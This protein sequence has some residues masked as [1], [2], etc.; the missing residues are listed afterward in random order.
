MI[1]IKLGDK[2]IN[3]TNDTIRIAS[4]DVGSVNFAQYIGDTDILKT[5]ELAKRYA[6]LPKT[7]QR[8]VKGKMN[9]EIKEILDE[10]CLAGKRVETGVFNF[11][12]EESVKLD[13]E[14][15]RNAILHLRKYKDVWDM[16]DVFVIEQ[17]YFRTF[18]P[19]GGKGGGTEANVDAIKMGEL[20]C[21]WFLDHYPTKT[22]MY[23]NSTFKTQIMGAPNGL[24]KPQ[25]K[26]WAV[27]KTR[28][29]YELRKDEEMI[30]IFLLKDRLFRKRIPNE[31]KIQ[32]YLDTFPG[33]QEDTKRLA[34]QMIQIRS[35]DR[36]KLDD[37]ADALVQCMAFIFK[38]LVAVF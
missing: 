31:E 6:A 34:K 8:R 30:E 2:D 18:K 15:R 1:K 14:T 24:T 13:M 9:D 26:K 27:E 20:V 28:E 25:R 7:K 4:I 23:F 16:C 11:R 29:I 35:E 21:G 12:G 3:V 33:V 22:V 37:I 5:I 10:V 19:K 36:Q 38:Y 32:F 17:Q